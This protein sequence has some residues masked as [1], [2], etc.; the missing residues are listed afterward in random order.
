[1][2]LRVHALTG[3]NFGRGSVVNL[4]FLDY[5]PIERRLWVRGVPCWGVGVPLVFFCFIEFEFSSWCLE[6]VHAVY[7]YWLALAIHPLMLVKSIK[8]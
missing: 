3:T 1:M 4:S 7:F 8:P 6:S 5:L 2:I